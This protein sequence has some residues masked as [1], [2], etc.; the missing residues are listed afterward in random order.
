MSIITRGINCRLPKDMETN[1]PIQDSGEG[2]GSPK[3]AKPLSSNLLYMDEGATE[4]DHR[5][6]WVFRLVQASRRI[7]T[8]RHVFP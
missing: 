3:V 5:D 2:Q 4:A 1:D 7:K 6:A 8:L